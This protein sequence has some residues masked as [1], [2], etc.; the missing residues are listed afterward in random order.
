MPI[1]KTEITHDWRV[2][3]LR[4]IAHQAK[5]LGASP[6]FIEDVLQEAV[7][8]IIDK[9]PEEGIPIGFQLAPRPPEGVM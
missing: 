3:E 7:A 1:Q 5:Q 6:G 9:N 2:K 8:L 4:E